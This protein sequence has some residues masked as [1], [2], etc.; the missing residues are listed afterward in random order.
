MMNKLPCLMLC[1]ALTLSAEENNKPPVE[2]RAQSID[3][4]YEAVEGAPCTVRLHVRAMPGYSLVEP[5]SASPLVGQDAA[6]RLLFGV[7]RG[8]EPCMENCCTL[9]YEF[10]TRPQGGWLEFNTAIDLQ[11]SHGCETLTLPKFNP[12][13]AAALQG[14]GMSF[15]FTP[16]PE[17]EAEPQ[18]V[19]F[20]LEYEAVPCIRKIAFY[21]AEGEPCESRVLSGDYS[22][23]DGL[24]HATY[25]LMLKGEQAYMQLDVSKPATR[26]QAP[27]QFRAY[28]G[29]L[30]DP[31]VK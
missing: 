8:C 17:D 2:L 18:A 24:T 27:V 28:I 5:E 15:Y 14:G 3:C 22:E 19:I 10:F 1:L 29:G 21:G 6:G 13:R 7:Y 4:T 23:Q 16:Q 25:L 26:V 12:R 11:V 9:V 30:T 20:L 31:G